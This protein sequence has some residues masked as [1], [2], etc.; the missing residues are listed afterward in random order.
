MNELELRAE[1]RRQGYLDADIDIM[2]GMKGDRLGQVE[3]LPF[4][5]VP[6]EGKPRANEH[7]C[8]IAP[9]TY[10]SY[11]RKNCYRRV[12]GKCIDF[13]FGIK[14]GAAKLVALYYKKTTWSAA[15]PKADC[16]TRGGTFHAAT[17]E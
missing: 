12:S 1:Y 13:L 2:L 11:A 17:G 5:C 6:D 8:D 10:D 15:D 4:G 16:K 9:G 7:S 3:A 14:A